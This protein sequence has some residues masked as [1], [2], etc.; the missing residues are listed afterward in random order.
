[1]SV[2]LHCH[3]L[4]SVDGFATPEEMADSAAA[5]GIV[6]LALTDHNTVEGLARCRARAEGLGLRFIDGVE[7]DAMWR[8]VEYHFV[9]FGFAPDDPALRRLCIRQFGQYEINFARFLPVLEQRYGVT[10][11][12]LA[13]GL[14]NYYRSR[15]EPVINK[16]Y[17]RSFLLSRGVFRDGKAATETMSEVAAEAER[18]VSKPWDWA[19][20][21]EVRDTVHAAGGLLL[22][23]HPAGYRRGNLRAQLGLIE[24]F[25]R[26]GL[27]GFE[28]YHPSNLLEPHFDALV[29]EARRLGCAVSGGSDS[30]RDPTRTVQ[31]P[32]GFAVPD[33][34][35]ETIDKALRGAMQQPQ[36]P[37][38]IQN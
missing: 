34:V 19:Q 5:A 36:P 2:E 9:A 25:L 26:I 24:G 6:T 21:E 37:P 32:R 28:L 33:W 20:V 14:P 8:E 12:D 22:L 3:S 17:A 4:F 35:I 18:G 31:A 27:D 29:S 11:Q 10:R 13:A 30:H 1:M 7:F 38:R 16:W 15:P 23:A